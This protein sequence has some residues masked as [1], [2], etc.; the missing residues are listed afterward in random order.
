M[1]TKYKEESISPADI[2]PNDHLI[3]STIYM[4]SSGHMQAALGKPTRKR[5]FHLQVMRIVEITK[6][7]YRSRMGG[8]V[9]LQTI[10]VMTNIGVVHF[11][12]RQ[13]VVRTSAPYIIPS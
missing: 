11:T 9:G 12:N 10:H 4:D 7:S 13:K 8:K 6:E 3:V 2:R 1:P 5:N